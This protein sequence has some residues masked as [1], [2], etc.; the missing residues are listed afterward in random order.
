MV[1]A[2]NTVIS[3]HQIRILD[4]QY[5]ELFLV[6]SATEMVAEPNPRPST[7]YYFG[8]FDSRSSIFCYFITEAAAVTFSHQFLR[9]FKLHLSKLRTVYARFT[10]ELTRQLCL[11]DATQ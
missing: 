5:K 1:L 7:I 8:C 4:I 3:F 10:S 6:G 9:V 2:G 11:V